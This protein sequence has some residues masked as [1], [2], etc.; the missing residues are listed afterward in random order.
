MTLK[1]GVTVKNGDIF[2]IHLY[3]IHHDTDQ[4]ISPEKFIPERFDSKN[5]FFKRPN[6]EKRHPFAF[7]PYLGGKRECVGKA[8]GE[9]IVSFTMPIIYHHLDLEFVRPDHQA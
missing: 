3:A 8:F 9:A 4:W 6:G 1:N 5:P 7:N 2:K